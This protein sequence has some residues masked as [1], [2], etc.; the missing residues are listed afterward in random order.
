MKKPSELSIFLKTFLILGAL[1]STIAFYQTWIQIREQGY[2]IWQSKRLFLLIGYSLNMIGA[3]SL[4]AWKPEKTFLIVQQ[5]I[6]ANVFWKPIGIAILLLNSVISP[7]FS[8]FDVNQFIARGF[9]L[10]WTAW[11]LSFVSASILYL[12]FRTPLPKLFWLS[13]LFI[14]VFSRIASFFPTVSTYPFSLGWSEASRYYYASLFFS[15]RLYGAPLPWSFLHPSRYLLQSIPFIF[16]RLPLWFHRLWQVTL[17]VGLSA[18]TSLTLAKRIVRGKNLLYLSLAAWFFIYMFQGAV[19]YHLQISV[20]IIFLGVKCERPKLSFIAV[21]LAS[22]W[23]GISRLN[24]IPIPA[25][26]AILL[27]LL[28]EPVS[29]FRN[30]RH[31][32]AK[33]TLWAI[34]GISAALTSQSLYAL[35]SGNTDNLSSFGSSFTSSL[36]WYRLLPNSTYLP[37]IIFATLLIS[38]PL[39]GFIA[40][41]LYKK[42]SHWHW[43]RLLG[44]WLMLLVLLIGGLVVSTKIGG[45]ADLHNMDAYIVFLGVWTSYMLTQRSASEKSREETTPP[46]HWGWIISLIIAPLWMSLQ[47]MNPMPIYDLEHAERSLNTL[48]DTVTQATQQGEEVLFIN[49]RHLLAL[50]LIE[51]TPLVADYEVITLMEMAMSDNRIYLDAFQQDLQ[52]HRFGL[53]ITSSQF[54]RLKETDQSFA[55]E[56]N[57]WV[58]NVGEHLRCQYELLFERKKEG[59]YFF[60]PKKELGICVFSE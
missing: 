18:A 60:V 19:Y 59:L 11:W 40:A 42:R 33:P 8:L 6:P 53:I 54:L 36:L 48:R 57:A 14:G 34:T 44:L 30:L 1:F 45:G 51:N 4:F 16:G 58:K 32:I 2:N 17:W 39:I 12:G 28:E 26:L 9:P 10:L 41:S 47:A 21:I 3:V 31:Y 20:L 56:H 52:E 35:R 24:W 49:Q 13:L 25:M 37:G 23:A 15:E 38:A 5:K 27:F 50:G 29:K 7:Y 55:E 22:L 43:I 46:L